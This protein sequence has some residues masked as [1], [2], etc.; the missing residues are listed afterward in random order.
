MVKYRESVCVLPFCRRIEEGETRG[1]SVSF[2]VL[3][4]NKQW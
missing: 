4:E 1:V 2:P 3:Q